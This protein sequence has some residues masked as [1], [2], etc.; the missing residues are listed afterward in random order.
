[1]KKKEKNNNNNAVDQRAALNQRIWQVVSLIP[2]GSVATYG[3]VARYAG[4]PGGARRVGYALR[5]L[6]AN[7]R[8]PWYRVVN[9]Q[10]R[11]ADLPNAE[12]ASNQRE[13]LEAE[14]ITFVRGRL[15]LAH[16]RWQ[17]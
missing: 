15:S 4:L 6:P 10:G 2:V 14:G 11:L 12:S 17:P 16:H 8:I 7:T 5:Q 3:D 9:A 1:M 13:R